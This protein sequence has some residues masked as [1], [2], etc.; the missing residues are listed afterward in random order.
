MWLNILKQTFVRFFALIIVLCIVSP[1]SISRRALGDYFNDGYIITLHEEEMNEASMYWKI[2]RF[3][4]GN[5]LYPWRGNDRD[6]LVSMCN[7]WHL[8]RCK[9]DIC[10]MP[11]VQGAYFRARKQCVLGPEIL[12][13]YAPGT[14][15]AVKRKDEATFECFDQIDGETVRTM[16]RESV[17]VAFFDVL[18]G[19][20]K[21]EEVF[22]IKDACL[23]QS[24]I[25]L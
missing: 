12:S 11:N 7:E 1:R 19:F 24:L 23:V 16:R 10:I 25:D 21:Q 3:V 5:H 22:R 2:H 6:K 15:A 14:L 13:H 8:G 17:R 9:S 18:G 20:V 4:L